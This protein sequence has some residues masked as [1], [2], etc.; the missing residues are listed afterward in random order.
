MISK[1]IGTIL[2]LIKVIKTFAEDAKVHKGGY[3]QF[4]GRRIKQLL[5]VVVGFLAAGQLFAQEPEAVPGEFLVRLKS[6]SLMAQDMKS[7]GQALG[8]TIV[9]QIP[10]RNVVIVKRAIVEKRM[11]TLAELNRNSFVEFAEPNFIYRI[12]GQRDEAPIAEVTPDDPDFLKLWGMKNT[13]QADSAGQAGVAGVDIGAT[14]AWAI[15]TG[16]KDIVVAVIDTGVNYNHQDIADNAWVN[17]AEL[18]GQPGVDDDGNG[19]VDDI[20]GYDFAN[21]DGDPMDDHGHGTHCSGTIGAKG[22]DGKAIVGVAWNVRIMGVKFLSGSGSGTLANAVKAIDY[23][24]LMGAQIQSNSWGGGGYSKELEDAIKRASDKGALFVAAAGNSSANNDKSPNYPSNY[25]VP[26]VLAVAAIDNRGQMASFSSYGRTTVDVAAPGVKIYSSTNTGYDSWSGT[27]MA[28]PHVS[29]IAALV[30]ANEQISVTDLKQR[31]ISTARPYSNLKGKVVSGGI[32]NAYLALTNTIPPPDPNDPT[33]WENANISVS[34]AH[35]YESNAEEV[36]EVEY[37]GAS[38]IALY[39]ERFET[40]NRYDVA[41][42]YNREGALVAELS[43]SLDKS[44]SPNIDGDYARIVFKTDASVVKYGFDIT[45][46][47][48]KMPSDLADNQ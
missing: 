13:G 17:E 27:S 14:Q 8:G 37:A 11:S 46:V 42:I 20:H 9:D 45:K 15:Q 30:L 48:Y 35:P 22:N 25:D 19:Y 40:E 43:G 6:T 31:I 3:M 16:S 47:A 1:S 29:G 12:N 23:A 39:F 36:F 28:T 33:T 32:A 24:T 21:N 10:N 26:N 2:E 34:S 18:N 44:F 7:L 4:H 41:R 5:T 38:K